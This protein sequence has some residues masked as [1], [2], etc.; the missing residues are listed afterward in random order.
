L[1]HFSLLLTQNMLRSFA[2]LLFILLGSTQASFDIE[3]QCFLP[4]GIAQQAVDACVQTSLSTEL[5]TTGV[6]VNDRRRELEATEEI[7]RELQNLCV[8][9][10]CSTSQAIPILCD[11]HNCPGWRRDLARASP[12]LSISSTT[13]LN[14]EL[15]LEDCIAAAVGSYSGTCTASIS[16]MN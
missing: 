9:Y 14:V 15:D 6:Q 11:R 4:A 1:F 8:L 16:N 12:G 3:L 7:E 13:L 2:A 5:Q 10:R